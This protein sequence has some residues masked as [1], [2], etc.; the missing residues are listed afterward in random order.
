MHPCLG[1]DIFKY[2][3]NKISQGQCTKI[4]RHLES[5]DGVNELYNIISPKNM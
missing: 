3:A 5:S 1:S 4:H 2:S